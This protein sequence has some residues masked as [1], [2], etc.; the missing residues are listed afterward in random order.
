MTKLA[1]LQ[2]SATAVRFQKNKGPGGGNSHSARTFYCCSH[3]FQLVKCCA[4]VLKVGAA[5][6]PEMFQGSQ[7]CSFTIRCHP[8]HSHRY[9]VW[10]ADAL[11]ADLYWCH[12]TTTVTSDSTHFCRL[13][14]TA[15]LLSDRLHHQY[16]L[17]LWGFLSLNE[18][19]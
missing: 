2:L 9:I 17:L 12:T 8:V 10:D 3:V 19:H 1:R 6:G 16:L 15:K 18:P 14:L 13:D 5:T 11:C 4:L 7:T